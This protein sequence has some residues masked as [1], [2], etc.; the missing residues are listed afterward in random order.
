MPLPCLVV[1]RDAECTRGACLSTVRAQPAVCA[2]C[3]AHVME[4][5]DQLHEEQGQRQALP[6]KP[7]GALNVVEAP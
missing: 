7:A 3:S 1:C 5:V 2:I 6:R 4:P